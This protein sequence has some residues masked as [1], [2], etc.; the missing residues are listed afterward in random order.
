MQDLILRRQ[1]SP[2]SRRRS[3]RRLRHRQCR[4]TVKRRDR[5]RGSNG[6]GKLTTRRRDQKRTRSRSRHPRSLDSRVYSGATRERKIGG[7]KLEEEINSKKLGRDLLAFLQVSS[8]KS[9]SNSGGLRMAHQM[10]I[11]NSKQLF[12][13]T[14]NC[15]IC[16]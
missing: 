7:A 8:V 6:G 9:Y 15:D 11:T 16:S 14:Y 10:Y 13:L 3:R 1:V 5:G 4:S 12:L 2:N